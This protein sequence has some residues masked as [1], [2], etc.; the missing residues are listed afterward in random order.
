MIH[1]SEILLYNELIYF[2]KLRIFT[3]T[4]DTRYCSQTSFTFVTMLGY[5]S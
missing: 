1:I 5:W 2:A 3:R 4:N